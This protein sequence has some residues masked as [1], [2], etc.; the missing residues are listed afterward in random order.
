MTDADDILQRI[1]DTARVS[2]DALEWFAQ[3]ESTSSWLKQQASPPRG[4]FRAVIAEHQTAGRGRNEKIWLSPPSSGVCLSVSYTF[5]DLPRN[6]PALTLAIGIGIAEALQKLG[7]RD[8]A[9]KWPNDLI[10]AGRKL[11]GILTEIQSAGDDGGRTVVVGIGVN[12]D[13]PDSI[14][15]AAPTAWTSGISD[16]AGCMD[17]VPDRAELAA[18][19]IAALIDSIRRFESEGLAALRSR[20]R[21]YDWLQGKT[22]SVQQ[23]AGD[24]TGVADGIDEDGALLVKTDAGTER[25]MSGSVRVAAYREVCA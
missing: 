8:V 24:I 20:W 17:G 3:L 11:G 18:V 9:L 5:G 7:A 22:V 2:L 19:I 6:L 16:L 23:A 21:A 10:A 15:Y 25:V 4:R 14:R 12:V 13:L 1:P